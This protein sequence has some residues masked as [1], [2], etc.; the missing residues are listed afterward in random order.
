MHSRREE[1]TADE[2]VDADAMRQFLSCAR[3]FT[4]SADLPANGASLLAFLSLQPDGVGW[5]TEAVKSCGLE[6]TVLI[7]AAEKLEE[8][9]HLSRTKV[10]VGRRRI[11][12]TQLSLTL[13]GRALVGKVNKRVKSDKAAP[14]T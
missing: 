1:P 8:L 13:K 7:R 11:L 5:Q 6:R 12:R 10:H 2:P 14:S 3:A 9:G 4:K